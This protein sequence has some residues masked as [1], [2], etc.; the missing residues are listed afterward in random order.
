MLYPNRDPITCAEICVTLNNE[1]LQNNSC[2]KLAV[3][4]ILFCINWQELP[5]FLCLKTLAISLFRF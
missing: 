1:Y 4:Y 5:V 2:A 3:Q